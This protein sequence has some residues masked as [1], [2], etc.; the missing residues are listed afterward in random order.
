M[1]DLKAVYAALDALDAFGERGDKKY[2]KIYQFG[3][4]TGPISALT[5]SIP[6]RFAG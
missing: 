3:E 5:S 4:P 1:A 6:G 2:L